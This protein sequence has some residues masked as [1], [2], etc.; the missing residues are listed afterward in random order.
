MK[1][2]LLYQIPRGCSFLAS[3]IYGLDMGTLKLALLGTWANRQKYK[4]GRPTN[5]PILV[6]GKSSRTHPS[7]PSCAPRWSDRYYYFCY[8]PDKDRSRPGP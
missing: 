8:R 4:C 1:S 3:R 7:Y 6:S 2:T 5:C